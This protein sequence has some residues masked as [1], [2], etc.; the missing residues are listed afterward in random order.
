[1]RRGYGSDFFMLREKEME[2]GAVKGKKRLTL[3]FWM[4]GKYKMRIS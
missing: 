3:S 2:L 4:N 1:M